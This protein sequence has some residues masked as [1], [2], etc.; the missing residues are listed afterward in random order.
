MEKSKSKW[1]T[2][3]HVFYVF[4]SQLSCLVWEAVECSLKFIV[5]LSY[6]MIII[7]FALGM[8]L[9]FLRAGFFGTLDFTDE[10]VS[11]LTDAINTVAQAISA[12]G[13]VGGGIAHAVSFGHVKKPHVSLHLSAHTILGSKFYKIENLVNVCRPYKGG[14]GLISLVLT[15]VSS[16]HVCPVTRYTYYSPTLYKATNAVLGWL[17]WDANPN[18]NNCHAPDMVDWCPYINMGYLLLWIMYVYIAIKAVEDF[19]PCIKIVLGWL[20]AVVLY[21]WHWLCV[22]V[23]RV[24]EYYTSTRKRSSS[25]TLAKEILRRVML[26]ESI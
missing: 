18:A 16:P 24:D 9:L 15:V 17:H 12:V 10:A 11:G 19:W 13:N 22:T 25:D 23:E 20:E 14:F 8:L 26:L 1:E 21:V 3:W 4:L 6:M 2:F 7:L 5:H